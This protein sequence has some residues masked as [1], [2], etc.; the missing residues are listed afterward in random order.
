MKIAHQFFQTDVLVI[1]AG[2]TGVRAAYEAARL[3]RHVTL[4]GR[5]NGSSDWIMGL[6][7]AV[8]PED[9]VELYW[10]DLMS[11][12]CG[13]GD[14]DILWRLAEGAGREVKALEQL[15]MHF[16]HTEEGLYHL[17]PTLGSTVPR[18]VHEGS[19]TGRRA[20]HLYL[21]AGMELGVHRLPDLR[22][23]ALLTDADHMI[24][25]LGIDL[26]TGDW[27]VVSCPA[28]VM[29]TGGI[30]CDHAVSTY[31]RTLSGDGCAMA[32]RAGARLVDMEFLQ[33]E[34]C[35]FVWPDVLRGKLFPTTLLNE[36]GKL[37]NGQGNPFLPEGEL[38]KS[39]LARLIAYEI[40]LGRGTPH[41]GVYYDLRHVDESTLKV[42]HSIFY[43]P[44]LQAGLD[45]TKTPAEVVPVAHT[46]LGG[47]AV[48]AACSTSVP[49]LFAAGEAAGGIHGANRVGGCAGAETL[50]FGA[51]AGQSAARCLG[52]AASKANCMQAAAEA[53]ERIPLGDT[54]PS[55]KTLWQQLH[56][57]ASE[58]LGVLR[59]EK[60]LLQARD[61]ICGLQKIPV[62]VR[63]SPQEI[64]QYCRWEN[65]LMVVDLQI[66]ASLARKS[67]CG[68]F[69][70]VDSDP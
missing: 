25:A 29:A 6:N 47:I 14:P 56:Q 17:I 64:L 3:G 48:D 68:V 52:Q 5:N 2:L 19:N 62:T 33:F 51:L 61:K 63:N 18:L 40:Y 57:A 13:C 7:A 37:V 38:Q 34:P 20:N 69:T 1:G 26:Q 32:M 54:S 8:S 12:A 30:G 65:T 24:G 39:D 27:V 21:Q 67:S 66:S 42:G 41:G 31:P 46:H 45:L 10:K 11:S 28:I 59:N 49:G 35:C 15:G 70:R 55:W 58:G 53:L 60:S 4:A 44:A 9:S 43:D 50:V 22:V 16:D 36:G 23:T